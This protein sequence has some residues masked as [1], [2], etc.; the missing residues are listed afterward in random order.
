VNAPNGYCRAATRSLHRGRMTLQ[1]WL[2]IGMVVLGACVADGDDPVASTTQAVSSG[3]VLARFRMT[4]AGAAVVTSTQ[5]A[6]W[7]I[8][9]LS[10]DRYVTDETPAPTYVSFGGGK[11]DPDSLTLG[12]YG[13]YYAAGYSDYASGELPP[14]SAHVTTNGARLQATVPANSDTFYSERCYYDARISYRACSS[15]E[16]YPLDLTWTSTGEVEVETGINE[17]DMGSITLRRAG[18]YAFTL[19]HTTGT[20]VDAPIHNEIDSYITS[21]AGNG[22][23]IELSPN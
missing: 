11:Q 18:R 6:P 19:A 12:P 1:H 14:G 21:D 9:Y 23:W 8:H 16:G 4:G 22:V 3:D 5:S 20:L 15:L 10:I 7:D 2:G 13:Y 17:L